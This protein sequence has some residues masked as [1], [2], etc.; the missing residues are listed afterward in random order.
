VSVIIFVHP[1]DLAFLFQA[2]SVAMN[3]MVDAVGIAKNPKD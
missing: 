1:K 2:E 3:V